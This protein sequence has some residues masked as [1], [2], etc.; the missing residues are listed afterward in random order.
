MKLNGNLSTLASMHSNLVTTINR[1]VQDDRQ[2]E[3]QYKIEDHLR[4]RVSQ[5]AQQ[6]LQLCQVSQAYSG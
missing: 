2:E 4:I 1:R 6:H 5:I 3:E